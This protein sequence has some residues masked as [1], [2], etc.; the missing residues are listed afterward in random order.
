[1]LT[2]DLSLLELYDLEKTLLRLQLSLYPGQVPKTPSPVA[3][4]LKTVLQYVRSQIRREENL[5]LVTDETAYE[6]F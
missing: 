5:L 3:L 4:G 2:Q 1:M 6:E